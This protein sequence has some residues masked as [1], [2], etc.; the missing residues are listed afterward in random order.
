[1]SLKVLEFSTQRDSNK[2]RLKILLQFL[3]DKH[4]FHENYA[5]DIQ[6]HTKYIDKVVAEP[7]SRFLSFMSG[8]R[9]D[10]LFHDSMADC[11]CLQRLHFGL[12]R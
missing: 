1:M 12:V 11:S 4:R 10:T 3:I 7:H 2:E 6:E 5:D 9:I 8:D